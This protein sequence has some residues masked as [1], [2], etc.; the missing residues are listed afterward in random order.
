MVL[1]FCNFCNY[2]TTQKCAYNRHLTSVKHKKNTTNSTQSPY[3]DMSNNIVINKIDKLAM[4]NQELK[5]EIEKLKIANNNNTNKVVKEARLIK[6][7]ILSI[8]NA[9]FK[10]TPSIAYIDEKQFRKELEIEYK[11]KISDEENGLFMR[12]FSDYENKKLIKTLSDLILKFVKKENYYNQSVFNI[13]SSRGNFATKI[14]DYWFND[15]SG[16]QL[17]KYTLDVIVQYM[18]NVLDIYGQRLERMIKEKNKTIARMDYIMLNQNLF[19]EVRA[20]LTNSNT[21][22]KVIIAMCPELRLDNKM[23]ESL[24]DNI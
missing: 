4:Q 1:H 13:D 5:Q 11:R 22:K 23:L 8:L 16:L 14:E 6:K 3:T 12:I 17:K 9:N 19:L 18:L 20:F 21:H 24:T 15:K 2:N 7:S 10:D